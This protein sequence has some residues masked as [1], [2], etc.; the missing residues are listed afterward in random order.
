MSFSRNS[1]FVG[2]RPVNNRSIKT[3]F[4]LIAV[5][6]FFMTC[7]KNS[8][9]VSPLPDNKISGKWRIDSLV[10]VFRDS[11]GNI[12][13]TQLYPMQAGVNYYFQFNND[14]TWSEPVTFGGTTGGDLNASNGSYVITS[15][16]AFDMSYANNQI[17]HCNITRLTS[18][19][20]VFNRSYPTLFNGTK[21]G[22][23]ERIFILKK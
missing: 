1:L 8:T 3:L 20:F 12:M 13:S 22:T 18:A 7:R 10:S 2:T 4:F 15:A 6:G 14:G 23:I 5:S 11:T 21:P 19:S 9:P 16:T 17:F